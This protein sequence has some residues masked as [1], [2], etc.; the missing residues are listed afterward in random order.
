MLLETL[1]F[2]IFYLNVSQNAILREFRLN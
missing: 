1:A 2:G